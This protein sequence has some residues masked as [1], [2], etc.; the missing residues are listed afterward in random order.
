LPANSRSTSAPN[1][2]HREI[3]PSPPTRPPTRPGS[4]AEIR[5]RGFVSALRLRREEVLNF[6]EYPFHIPASRTLDRL[7]LHPAVTFFIGENGSGKSTLLEA[8]A[9]KLRFNAEGGSR[10]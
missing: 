3:S 9:L 8:I 6:D 10:R 5:W 2:V 4:E 1:L 7:E